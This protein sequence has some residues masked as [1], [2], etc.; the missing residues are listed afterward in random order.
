MTPAQEEEI[1]RC[2]YACV[3]KLDW[4]LDECLGGK[5]MPQESFRNN[6][7]SSAVNHHFDHLQSCVIAQNALDPYK[8]LCWYGWALLEHIVLS[9]REMAFKVI[10]S[11]LLPLN[12]IL[13]KEI[14]RSKKGLP[15]S[16]LRL[17]ETML[18]NEWAGAVK[19]GIGKNGLYVAFHCAASNGAKK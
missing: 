9:E 1:I 5:G 13:A 15:E 2:A 16:S 12:Y 3:R 11:T 14:H 8:F 19:H 7:A 4:F 17:L 10:K 6:A 18:L